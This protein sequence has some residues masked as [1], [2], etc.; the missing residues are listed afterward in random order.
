MLE[1]HLVESKESKEEKE[2]K[3]ERSPGLL[4]LFFN[5]HGTRIRVALPCV[6]LISIPGVTE[7]EGRKSG[8]LSI[9]SW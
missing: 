5:C 6:V 9:N 1:H 3:A 2:Q 7:E 4:V 8:V